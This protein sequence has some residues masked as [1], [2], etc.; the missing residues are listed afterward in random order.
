MS[1]RDQFAKPSGTMGWIAGHLMAMKNGHRSTWVFSL[2]DLKPTDRVLE[3]G[4][5]PISPAPAK[6]RRS[7][8]EWIIQT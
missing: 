8:P 3:I 6:P 2:L 5:G 4:F 1:W 7:W